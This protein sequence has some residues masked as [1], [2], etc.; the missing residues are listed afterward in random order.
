M[1][2]YIAYLLLSAVLLVAGGCGDDS[3]IFYSITYPVVRIDAEVTLPEPEEPEEPS[4]GEDSGTEGTD[5]KDTG[6]SRDLAENGSGLAEETVA[7]T[8]RREVKG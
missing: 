2:K 3:E 7:G 6:R 1:R 4:T 8:G 5:R